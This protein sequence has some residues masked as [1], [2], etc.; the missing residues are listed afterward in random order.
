MNTTTMMM[1]VAVSI[2]MIFFH[3]E[4]S[5]SNLDREEFDNFITHDVPEHDENENGE[6]D[7][8]YIPTTDAGDLAFEIEK[9]DDLKQ[10]RGVNISGHVILNFVGTLLTRKQHT[11]KSSSIHKY[12]LH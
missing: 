1:T 11:L 3:N 5:D 6:L 10:T 9:N 7:D 8:F 12:F 2:L 4:V